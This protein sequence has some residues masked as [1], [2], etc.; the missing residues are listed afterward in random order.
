MSYSADEFWCLRSTVY[1]LPLVEFKK[2]FAVVIKMKSFLKRF[3]V[4]G[5]VR[6]CGEC[7][8]KH[9]EN[10]VLDPVNLHILINMSMSRS[11]ADYIKELFKVC[12]EYR[13]DCVVCRKSECEIR[14]PPEN[15]SC[16]E[17]YARARDEEN[18]ENIDPSPN[19]PLPRSRLQ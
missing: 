4:D 12:P 18:K 7:Y 9:F 8:V 19:A 14:D 13:F 10:T 17:E 11:I 1:E 2:Q 5:K 15:C 3:C 6:I 16:Y